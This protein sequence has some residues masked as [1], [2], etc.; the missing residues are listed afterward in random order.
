MLVTALFVLRRHSQKLS[1]KIWEA[2]QSEQRNNNHES[3]MLNA[4]NPTLANPRKMPHS[5]AAVFRD[6]LGMRQQYECPIV[7][8]DLYELNH[9]QFS[10]RY[11]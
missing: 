11:V 3:I 6:T 5:Y 1:W 2:M 4:E 7:V 10:Y 8:H 9:E